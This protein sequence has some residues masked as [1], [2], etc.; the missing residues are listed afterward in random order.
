MRKT[1]LC[2]IILITFLILF[3]IFANLAF[4]T[5]ETTNSIDDDILAS[6]ETNYTFLSN[7]AFLYG[8]DVQLSQIVDGNAFVYGGTV[9]VSGEIYGDLFVFANSLNITKDAIIHGN[10]FALSND[11]SISG[12]VSDVYAISSNTFSLEKDSIIARN[13]NITS[14]FVTLSGQVSRDA[15]I[16]VSENLSFLKDAKEVIKGNLNYTSNVEAQIPEG[17]VV[18]DVKYTSIQVDNSNKILDI[19]TNIITSLIFSFVIIMLSMWITPKFSDRICQIISKKSLKALGIGL[20]VFFVIIIISIL[21]LLFTYGFGSTIAVWAI[22]LLIVVYSISNTIFSMSLGKLIANKLHKNTNT[23]FV[24]ISLLFVLILNLIEYIPYIG[25]PITFLTAI[26]GL[27]IISINA[28][29]RK[30][31][32]NNENKVE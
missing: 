15:N 32:V 8:L 3:F 12:L 28:Y 2:R 31:L 9:T 11:I 18:G 5:N 22:G 26:I 23:I 10:L 13:L 27:G 16:Y 19:I 30:D 25:G 20:L 29:K 6:Y 21:L 14:N 7:D 24:L 4:A 1:F 17:A